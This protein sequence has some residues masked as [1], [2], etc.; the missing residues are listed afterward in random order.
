VR[1]VRLALAAGLIVMA[2]TL[3][4]VLSRS[5]LTLAGSN[6]IPAKA[7]VA[8][9]HG[10]ETFC[11]PGGTM[12]E[13]TQAIRVS[14][15]ANAG[16][17][18]NLE[19]LSG[20]AVV[21][22]GA[23][24]AGWG[25]Q[26]SVTVPV[27]RVP[28][29]IGDTR[30]C[31]AIGPVVEYIQI[32]GELV[33]SAP[34]HWLRM[35]YLRPGRS[36]WLSLASTV[37]RNMGIVHAPS[38]AW[39]A[40]LLIAVM[41]AV[42][43]LASRL[44]LAEAEIPRAAWTCAL[45]ASLSA[46]CW[47]LITPPFQVPDEPSHFAYAQLFAETGRL[48][49]SN[50]ASFSEEE[51]VVLKDLHQHA[52]QWH[53]EV[54]SISSRPEEQKLGEDLASHLARAGPGGAGPAASDPPG[55]Y[56]LE[57]IP[58]YLGSGGTLLDRLELMRLLSALMAGLAALFTFLFIRESLPRVPW[59]W[60]VG[61][62]G[63]ALT[64]LLGFA[65]GAVSPDAM[66]CAV[67]A[68]I[69][70]CL[71]RGFRRGL[72]RRLAV[73]IG[74]LTAVGF[75]TKL[76]FIGLAPGVMLGLVVLALRGERSGRGADQS[77]RAFVSV[78]IATAIALSPGCVYVLSNLL[79]HHHTLGMVSSA[80]QDAVRESILSTISYVWQFYLPR[81]PGMVNYF[82]GLATTRHLWFDK[83]V[84]DYGWLDTR[85]PLWVYNLALVPAGLIA[86]LGLLTAIARR[87]V[88]RARLPEMLVYL[89]MG[90]GLM[91]LVGVSSD[92]ARLLEGA[93]YAQARYLLP[94]LPIGGA[95]LALAVRGA[96][97]RWGPA[98][99]AL[100]VV[101]FLAHDVFSQLLVAAR[102]YG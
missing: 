68:A 97:R 28:R 6:G 101:L 13:G 77:R 43:I 53:P 12:P 85:F 86:I 74:V 29:T 41:I 26:E 73:V 80:Y 49:S 96:G 27:R 38:G 40:Y 39:V 70:Y 92:A 88:L 11:Q 91:G 93:A 71:A 83:V 60:T 52:I 3:A 78:A 87:S 37:A 58:Y 75:L 33:R 7:A 15:S 102:F 67:S 69:F 34:G 72:T 17:K 24:A 19:V 21:T 79:G 89:A 51:E 64:P 42:C 20:T 61:G 45:V 23:R 2:A 46:G 84:G 62:L 81:L 9:I 94:L 25:I 66:L 100:I 57:A 18:V 99:G 63:A 5:P 44:L 32:N 4:V 90:V 10:R 59:A 30:I 1:R 82:P 50:S 54:E 16:P 14:L 55:F 22:E 48:P 95:L 56:G 98:V 31:V 36:S 65:S 8:Y 47:S 76:N 35:E